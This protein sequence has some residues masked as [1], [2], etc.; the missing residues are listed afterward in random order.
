MTRLH[1]AASRHNAHSPRFPAQI[2]RSAACRIASANG[3]APTRFVH[4]P[5]RP[6]YLVLDA[7]STELTRLTTV[8]INTYLAAD[9]G[10][11][12]RKGGETMERYSAI[13]R[14]CHRKPQ[15]SR[16][17]IFSYGRSMGAPLSPLFSQYYFYAAPRGLPRA[18]LT[19]L[20]RERLRYACGAFCTRTR[21]RCWSIVAPPTTAA[22]ALLVV[23]AG[24]GALRGYVAQREL[25][26]PQPRLATPGRPWSAPCVVC[27]SRR[28][29]VDVEVLVHLLREE[30][31]EGGE[32]LREESVMRAREALPSPTSPSSYP[33]RR[34]LLLPLCPAG[35]WY[36]APARNL[37]G[38]RMPCRMRV[39]WAQGSC[40]GW[41][42]LA[43]HHSFPDAASSALSHPT[44]RRVR[45]G[46]Q[47]P[48]RLRL[49]G[50]ESDIGVVITASHCSHYLWYSSFLRRCLAAHGCRD[51]AFS[52]L[53][54]QGREL[55]RSP[56]LRFSY[57][58]RRSSLLLQLCLAAHR[59]RCGW[60]RGR[61]FVTDVSNADVVRYADVARSRI[62]TSGDM[63]C[64][65]ALRSPILPCTMWRAGSCAVRGGAG[66]VVPAREYIVDCACVFLV[67]VPGTDERSGCGYR[68][69]WVRQA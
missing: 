15:P 43:P 27:Y 59:W 61:G 12:G 62:V 34:N 2:A 21:P 28:Q 22:P 36:W 39:S 3:Y 42:P 55:R 45:A 9:Q 67:V 47:G 53:R 48:R 16:A 64:I 65:G 4:A 60:G 66:T 31:E 10:G 49:R 56:A 5:G 41:S 50:V 58:L 6:S 35:S 68:L 38:E 63:F 40:R 57:S 7:Q 1:A 44:R 54:R 23:G 25:R 13:V 8:V 14:F 51:R 18:L 11:A 29:D 69:A 37:D 32:S 24:A 26:A 19:S 33:L 17:S 46:P 52:A 20:N 30:E